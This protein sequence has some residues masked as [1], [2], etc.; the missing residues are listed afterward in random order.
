MIENC[1]DE[2]STNREGDDDTNDEGDGS[3]VDVVLP[4][5]RAQEGI[6][7]EA[8]EVVWI[9]EE[10]NETDDGHDDLDDNKDYHDNLLLHLL[11]VG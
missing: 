11:I 9:K 5:R 7:L 10:T 4:H 8:F 2:I 3:P 1:F 6:I